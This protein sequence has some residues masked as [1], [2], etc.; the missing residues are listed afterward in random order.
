MNL[1]DLKTRYQIRTGRFETPLDTDVPYWLVSLLFHL[2]LL[3]LM[4]KFILPGQIDKIM[5]L[6]LDEPVQEIELIDDIP[7]VEFSDLL[8]DEIGMEGDIGF[9][10]AASQAPM[11][12]IVDY[13]P[14]QMDLT[15]HDFG[16]L[17]S[18]NEF[19]E[20]GA[21]TISDMT[22]KGSVGV[23]ASAAS[24]AV[25]AIT[26][27]IVESL[28]ERPTT[29][30]WLFDQSASMVKQRQEIQDRF[31]RIYE[32]VNI[33]KDAGHIS[34]Q[35]HGDAIALLT[36]VYAFGAN[37]QR[38]LPEPSEDIAMIAE[39]IANITRDESGI[40][41]VMQAVATA[42]TEHAKYRV[43]KSRA[44]FERNVMLIVVTDEAGDDTNRLDETLRICQ[45]H[46]MPVYV[47]GIPAPFGR[48]ET[49]VKWVDPD[50]AYD[51]SE[52]IAR[53]SQGP[54]TALP[55][56]LR[57]D[58]TGAFDDLDLIDS[59]FGPFHL[60]RL[61]YE[62]GGIYF[63]VHPNR[64]VGRQVSRR[65]VDAYSSLLRHFFD[66]EVMRHY[67]PDYVSQDHYTKSAQTNPCRQAL[68]QA[69]VFT[70]TG[71]L[72]SPQLRFPKF[73]EASFVN[74]ITTAQRTAAII[75]PQINRVYEILRTGEQ[76]RP[77]EISRRWKAGYDLAMGQAIAAKLRAESYNA[78]L[79][80][81]KTRLKF[82]PPRDENTP[83]NNTWVL[84]PAD[85]IETGSQAQKLMEKGK[86]YLT[87]VVE[88]HPDTPWAMLAQRELSIPMGW[89]WEETYTRPP[90]PERPNPN[91]NNNVR[92]PEQ[93]RENE[94]P[95]PRREIPRL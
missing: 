75:E 39:K 85:S 81:A 30:V 87:R 8:T 40:E 56:R 58:L 47:I 66:P 6:S 48:A 71:T 7:E 38:L 41:N 23:V 55:E 18:S 25:D 60:T 76:A 24:G 79:A 92:R 43:K 14:P 72:D 89:R 88:E 82:S 50:P 1:R 74:Q 11:I 33:L 80:M 32:E 62:T 27:R 95:R 31:E 91:N 93:P 37:V 84:R 68:V 12:Q 9:D 13:Q 3:I 70:T 59:G 20:G 64:R 46:Q 94:M 90:E 73:D 26:I 69:S 17:M 78:M 22:I 53:V 42:A 65:E 83:Q 52:Q 36:Q 28:K 77:K 2:A 35:D 5:R 4:A 16:E 15:L 63:A 67:K 44:G 19:I 51:Q 21:E 45:K 61:C 86:S 34:R 10:A 54:E 57:M 29:V 49:L